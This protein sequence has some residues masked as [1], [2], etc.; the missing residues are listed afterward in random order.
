LD[1]PRRGRRAARRSGALAENDVD[2]RRSVRAVT[3]GMK[4]VEAT[5]KL[6]SRGLNI[7]DLQK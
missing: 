3:P 6:E 4:R 2:V 5:R 7:A 1:C